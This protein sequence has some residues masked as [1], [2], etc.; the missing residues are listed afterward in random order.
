MQSVR[1]E[2]PEL[3]DKRTVEVRQAADVPDVSPPEVL[4]YRAPQ[5]DGPGPTAIDIFK[6]TAAVG[7]TLLFLAVALCISVLLLDRGGVPD[8][9]DDAIAAPAI[10]MLLLLLGAWIS[11]R[12]ARD[13]FTG[14]IR[15]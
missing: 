8:G 6:G 4:P 10:V 13:C 9:K 7:L 12:A 2:A 1:S 14:A 3:P 15:R 11:Y 5:D